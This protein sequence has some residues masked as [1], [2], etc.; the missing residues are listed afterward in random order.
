MSGG[1]EETN[2]INSLTHLCSV[3][4]KGPTRYRI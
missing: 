4:R 2:E 1:S 3:R